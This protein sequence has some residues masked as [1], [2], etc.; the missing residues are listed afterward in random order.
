MEPG[1]IVEYIENQ[2]IVCSVILDIKKQRLRLLTEGNREVNLAATRLSHKSKDR[3]ALTIGRDKLVGSLKKN[4]A[5]RK[6]LMN[7]IDIKALWDVLHTE[8]E[9]IDLDTMTAFSFS[10]PI[11][12]D[13]GAAVVRAFF[14]N[15]LYFKFDHNRFLPYSE[16]QVERNLAQIRKAEHEKKVIKAGSDWL[17]HAMSGSDPQPLSDDTREY[18]DIV[19]S[20]YL[21]ET[22]SPHY[23]LG[24][25]MLSHAGLNADV[26]IPQ[27]LIKLGVWEKDENVDLLRHEIPTSFPDEVIHQ[28]ESFSE[29]ISSNGNRRDLTELPL[30]TIDGPQTLD[31]D[32]ALSFEKTGNTYRLGVHIVDV[33]Q[34]VP[35]GGIVDQ[36]ALRRGSSIYMPDKNISMLPP[37]LAEDL[38][39]LK[40]GSER[41]AISLFISLDRFGGIIDHEIFPSLINV[42]HRLTYSQADEMAKTDEKIKILQE[43]AGVFQEKR[44]KSGAVNI[45]LPEIYTELNDSKEVVI[46]RTDRETPGRMIVSEMMI[47]ANGLMAGFLGDNDMPAIFRAQ[48]EPKNRLIKEDGGT[49]FQ[50]WMQR[51]HLSRVVLGMKPEPHSGLGLSAYVTAT[52]PIR[53]YFDLVTQRQ[54]R[55]VLGMEKPYTKKEI[56]FIIH[57]LEEPLR[58]V[59][60]IQFARQR[61]WLLK[62]MEGQI[63][64]KEG[65][66]VLEKRRDT[67][68]VLLVKYM[69]ECRLSQPAVTTLKPQDIVQVTIQYANAR[70]DALSV[71]MG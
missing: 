48:P 56:M 9:W 64:K 58:N 15:R 62:F 11:T 65:A 3:L 54:I 42:T 7:K 18:I 70:N 16:I 59:A 33:G 40:T 50:N 35:R 23:R 34:S 52:S 63:G 27:F 4:A 28:A 53:K 21:F 66:I 55:A 31:F 24:K 61:Y 2:K 67:T 36:E 5:L 10:P 30:M 13:H 25:D 45:N 44:L 60:K 57:T 49:L 1:N 51:R 8:A 47:L 12:P 38:C 46:H 69:I 29:G 37:R 32:D 43:F 17:R 71:Y 19:Q 22:E 14:N 68:I 39:S 26:N 6:S 41:P 20:Y